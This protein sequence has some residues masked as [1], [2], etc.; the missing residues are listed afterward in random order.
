VKEIPHF[1][2]L[3]FRWWLRSATCSNFDGK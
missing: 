3:L 2:G 1:Q